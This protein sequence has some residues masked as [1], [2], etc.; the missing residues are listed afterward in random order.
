MRRIWTETLQLSSEQRDTNCSGFMVCDGTF[1]LKVTGSNVHFHFK[2]VVMIEASV[3]SEV[4]VLELRPRTR[5]V[6]YL[7]T[8]LSVHPSLTQTSSSFFVLCPL[9][10]LSF[11]HWALI[12]RVTESQIP[13]GSPPV[14]PTDELLHLPTTLFSPPIPSSLHPSTSDLVSESRV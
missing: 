10:S 7:N 11:R 3:W 9:V 2:S 8:P 14:C 1:I 13:P 6:R 5:Y 4:T 12:Q